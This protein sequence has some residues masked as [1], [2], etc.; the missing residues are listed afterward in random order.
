MLWIRYTPLWFFLVSVKMKLQD[1]VDM[2]KEIE[3]LR[4][5]RDLLRNVQWVLNKKNAQ[6]SQDQIV[7]INDYFNYDEDR[8]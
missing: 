1:I 2:A 6:F 8:E 4:K 7:K 3:N 5:A